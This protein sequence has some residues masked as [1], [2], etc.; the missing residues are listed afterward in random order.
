MAYKTREQALAYYKAYRLKHGD[1]LREQERNRRK[2]RSIGRMTHRMAT[3]NDD[4]FRLHLNPD[5][6][7]VFIEGVKLDAKRFWDWTHQESENLE[8]CLLRRGIVCP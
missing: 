4:G 5:G 8:A 2:E 6:S 7:C 3:G 1:R